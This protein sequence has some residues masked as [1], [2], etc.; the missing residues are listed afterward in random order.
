MK[1]CVLFSSFLALSFTIIAQT[2]TVTLTSQKQ[3]IRGFGGI[4]IPSW[5]GGD[6]T[7]A[8]RT[9]AFG[10]GTG[11]IGMSILRIIVDDNTANWSQEVPTAKAA[12]QNG[13][14]V[15]ATP[16]NPPIALTETVTVNNQQVKRL[17]Y[18]SYG[19]YVTHL[20]NFNTYM[21][22]NGVDLFAISIQN[23]P[24]YGADW[25]WWTASEVYN[26]TKNNAGALTANKV[27]TAE[28]F[29]YSKSYYDQILNDPTA[30]ANIDIIGCHFYGSDPTTTASSF[31]QY[32]LADSKAL[33]KERWMTEHYT[34]STANSGNLWPDALNVALEISRA[35]V[36]GQMSA[37]VWWYI[38]RSYGP[39][40]E[41]GTV[42]KRGYCMSQFSKF[43][44]PGYYRVDAT[45]K[46]TSGV[47]FSAYKNGNDVVLV[48]VNTN[49]S[50][51]SITI[52]VPGTKVTSWTPYTTSSSKN[53]AQGTSISS[54]GSFKV[55]LDASSVTTF[56]GKGIVTGLEDMTEEQEALVYPNP[57]QSEGMYIELSGDFNYKITDASGIAME[58]G[59]AHSNKIVGQNLPNGIYFLTLQN[60]T[61]SSTRKMV[62]Q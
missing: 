51:S 4:S 24:D 11:Q 31:Y 52:S 45:Q 18:A 28:S 7:A 27:I 17:K 1:K 42:S 35:M 15:F 50:A 62:K 59:N 55:T 5:Q 26:F 46:P 43:I 48:A 9:T 54:S 47:N 3:Y 57:F 60:G 40:L 41:D 25:T 12:I 22:N 56:V 10:N 44:R 30:L 39:I 32:P 34:N 19:D 8:Q 58:E 33:N 23:E 36:E 37:Y 61:K 21:K 29:S 49:T 13:A 6:L 38:R 16:W 14:I 2:A 53:V 20:N